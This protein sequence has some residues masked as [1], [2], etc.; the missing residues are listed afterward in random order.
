MQQ[1]EQLQSATGSEQLTEFVDAL[2]ARKYP[3]EPIENHTSDREAA[4]EALTD[5]VETELV[6]RLDEDQQRSLNA[7]AEQDGDTPA[8]F[9]DFLTKAGI[10]FNQIVKDTMLEFANSFLGGGNAQ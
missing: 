10:N 3:G 8:A 6:N 1:A 4:I 7:I 2:I 5:A 9:L